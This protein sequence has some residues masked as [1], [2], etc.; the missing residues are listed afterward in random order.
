[1]HWQVRRNGLDLLYTT[2]QVPSPGMEAR[3]SLG[4]VPGLKNVF[5]A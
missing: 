1:M 2:L 5:D 3:E 4:P